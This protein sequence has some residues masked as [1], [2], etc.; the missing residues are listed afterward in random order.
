M[1][2]AFAVVAAVRVWIVTSLA[3]NGRI[4]NGY[5]DAG[6]ADTIFVAGAMLVGVSV[7]ALVLHVFGR[8]WIPALLS[9]LLMAGTTL[10]VLAVILTVVYFAPKRPH[11]WVYSSTREAYYVLC[12]AALFTDTGYVVAR[13]PG[14]LRPIWGKAFDPMILD[15]SDD[16]SLTS[17]PGL[18]LSGDQSILVVSRGRE[19]TD[20]VDIDRGRD[21]TGIIEWT[22]TNRGE[23]WADRT[24]RVHEILMKHAG[25][26]H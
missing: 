6:L 19:L 10:V 7:V 2:L 24:R 11:A 25:P 4:L 15:R 14:L 17:D 26:P 8:Q 3:R 18:L 12:D 20:A 13:T 23:L 5:L 16:R 22:S 9:F 21:L 1:L